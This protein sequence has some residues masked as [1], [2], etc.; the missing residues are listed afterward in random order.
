M[1]DAS[2]ESGATSPAVVAVLALVVGSLLVAGAVAQTQSPATGDE[3]LENVHRTYERAETV[4]G[5]A[6]VN[7][8]D[9][10][11]AA[12]ATVEF[13]YADENRTRLVVH[14]DGHTVVAGVNGTAAWLYDPTTGHLRVWDGSRSVATHDAAERFGALENRTGWREANVTATRL[15]TVTENGT[16]LAV[17]RVEPENE[18]RPGTA[19]L[20]V[21]TGD[22]T[23]R[24]ERL[25][26]G[27]NET[28]LTFEAVRFNVSIHESTFDPPTDSASR[29]PGVSR[30]RYDSL[31]AARSS[32]NLSLPTLAAD[33]YAFE[34][35]LATSARGETTVVQR[36]RADS[37]APSPV[38]L[39]TTTA[40]ELPFERSNV[41]TV[42]LNGHTATV[43]DVR[44]R[45]V[46]A[47]RTDETIRAVVADG[48]RDDV[49]ALARS[50]LS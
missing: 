16:E 47:W 3:V 19:T 13:A 10:S 50:V 21:D 17:V 33:G 43:G 27:T 5:T 2:R 34:A 7:A 20:W 39:L 46:V 4:T 8:T 26:V 32:V 49:V 38:L 41:T 29:L 25:S 28:D 37:T 36:Y 30:E 35:A 48:P 14:R 1:A 42:D 24:R 31:A 18:S 11:R 12:S 40:D 23:V 44:G 9:G 15:R 22:W 45:T 6:T